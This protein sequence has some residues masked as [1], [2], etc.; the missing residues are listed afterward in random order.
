M[1]AENDSAAP[2]LHLRRHWGRARRGGTEGARPVHP[3]GEGKAAVKGRLHLATGRKV[4][5]TPRSTLYTFYTE[6][7]M[8]YAKR[9]LNDSTAR[10]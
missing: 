1:T 5:Q 4:I 6:S 7:R 10:G 2:R 9:G 8:K 3:R